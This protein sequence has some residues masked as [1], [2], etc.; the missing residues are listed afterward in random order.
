MPPRDLHA[1]GCAA[2]QNR[3]R[4]RVAVEAKS[5]R[6]FAQSFLKFISVICV[7]KA[8]KKLNPICLSKP[9]PKATPSIRPPI[10]PPALS[11]NHYANPRMVSSAPFPHPPAEP[12][13]I[14]ASPPSNNYPPTPKRKS[15]HSTAWA[16]PRFQNFA[17]LWQS[18]V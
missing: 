1:R 2:G 12:S 9:A 16:N 4:G 3:G 5:L 17:Q 13:K 10:A 8:V 7:Q 11:A 15:L 14:T 6:K 18:R